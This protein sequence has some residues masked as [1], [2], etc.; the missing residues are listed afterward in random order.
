MTLERPPLFPSPLRSAVSFSIQLGSPM[1]V[2]SERL[3]FGRVSAYAEYQRLISRKAT[4]KHTSRLLCTVFA[5]LLFLEHLEAQDW[6]R[7]HPIDSG[8]RLTSVSVVDSMH[9]WGCGWHDSAAGLVVRT[10]DGGNNWTEMS[11]AFPRFVND[12]HFVTDSLG[13]IVIGDNN[14][15]SGYVLRTTDGGLSWTSQFTDPSNRFFSV[16][17]LDEMRGWVCGDSGKILATTNA[18][19]DWQTQESGRRVSF[20]DIFLFQNGTGW[21]GPLRTTNFGIQWD[22]ISNISLWRFSFLNDSLGWAVGGNRYWWTTDGGRAWSS[23]FLPYPLYYATYATDV[24]ALSDSLVLSTIWDYRVD[25]PFDYFPVTMLNLTRFP[26]IETRAQILFAI[27]FT[28]TGHGFAVGNDDIVSSRDSGQT[29][30]NQAGSLRWSLLDIDMVDDSTGWVVGEKELIM[31]T[32]DGGVHWKAQSVA[33]P[34]ALW[35]VAGIDE[36]RAFA[37]GTAFMSTTNGGA[38]WVRTALPEFSII[39]DLSFLDSQTGWAA[40]DQYK[41]LHTTDGGITWQEQPVPVRLWTIDFVD[42]QYGWCAGE[43]GVIYATTNGGIT[44]TIQANR[45][46][47]IFSSLDFVD[48]DYGWV[49]GGHLILRTTNG[50]TDWLTSDSTLNTEYRGVHFVNRDTGWAVG[51]YRRIIATTNGGITWIVQSAGSQFEPSYLAIGAVSSRLVWISGQQGE[52]LHTTNGGGITTVKSAGTETPTGFELDQNYPN[53]F[54]PSTQINF[55]LPVAGAVSLTIYDVLG[56]KVAELANGYRE[57][58]S[59]SVT[60]N[61]GAHLASGVYLARFA[62]ANEEGRQLYAKSMKLMLMK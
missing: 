27:D 52:I 18:G 34:G 23:E 60:W 3:E 1:Q 42:S 41:V 5:V 10:T 30:T 47:S 24:V 29:W 6:H 51:A 31:R 50:G 44:W 62:V 25:P 28:K 37:G 53:P 54:N 19:A 38:T 43:S 22:S 8:W 20:A 26:P 2:G 40:T 57:A 14:Q 56:R 12:I 55:D 7:Q 4:K 11:R 61:A 21:C 48:R 39:S 36:E 32:T 33:A 9:A 49:A 13:W 16:F 15:Y 59:H 17:F 35:S 45:A 46:V 58:G